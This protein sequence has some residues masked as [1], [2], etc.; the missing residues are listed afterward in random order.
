[1]SEKIVP[2]TD[3]NLKGMRVVHFTN[4]NGKEVFVSYDPIMWGDLDDKMKPY[5]NWSIFRQNDETKKDVIIRVCGSMEYY[6]EICAVWP[7]SEAKGGGGGGG[8]PAS[9]P[10]TQRPALEAPRAPVKG[11]RAMSEFF[12]TLAEAGG[13][14][15]SMAPWHKPPPPLIEGFYPLED[16][17]FLAKEQK[18]RELQKKLEDAQDNMEMDPCAFG[19]IAKTYADGIK[20]LKA[21]RHAISAR[22]A[23]AEARRK[24]VR[25]ER[26]A[27]LEANGVPT[28]LVLHARLGPD[29]GNLAD[30]E[31]EV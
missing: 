8:G 28:T 1:M 11:N 4:P 15:A 3:F 7:R 9:P 23:E 24:K 19:L 26:E 29:W 25:E 14:G 20:E 31:E 30:S 22:R 12:P 17:E 13:G 18:V 2:Y 16:A 10:R 21:L 5:R 6:E 27:V